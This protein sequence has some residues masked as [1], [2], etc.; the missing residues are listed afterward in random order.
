[1]TKTL[2]LLSL[3]ALCG[4]SM[5]ACVS[6]EEYDK[7]AEAY[8]TAQMRNDQLLADAE[9]RQRELDAK[10]AR[11]AEVE[12]ANRQLAGLSDEM[13]RQL[14]QYKME[15]DGFGS[16]IAG[17]DLTRLD[18]ATNAELEALAA[19][20]PDLMMYDGTRG[21][22]RLAADL[23]F[24]S[25]SDSVKEP[26]RNALGRLAGVLNDSNAGKYDIRIV[27]HTDRQ[28]ITNPNTRA[29]FGS[30]RVLSCF[31]AIAVE[32]SLAS[33]GVAT[34]RMECAGWGEYQ[35]AVETDRLNV[36]ENRRVE[37]FLV[38]SVGAKAMGAPMGSAGAAPTMTMQPAAANTMPAPAPRPAAPEKKEM[39]FK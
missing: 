25:G 20:Y 32:K 36:R 37:L 9:A 34:N 22:I 35:P 17:M 8:R 24:D 6:V 38:P 2:K 3:F 1:M 13:K 31:R 23:T 18:P 33:F 14:D 28:P 29:R 7:T 10:N 4:V 39:P 19:Q 21:M 27:G 15:L 16:K 11:L 5:T 12:D 30:N 26:A